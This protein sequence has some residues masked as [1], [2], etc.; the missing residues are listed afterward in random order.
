MLILD[1][2]VRSSELK[3]ANLSEG[4]LRTEIEKF[5][6]ARGGPEDILVAALNTQGKFFYQLKD[7]ARHRA[8]IQGG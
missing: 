5:G 1:G 8:N 6:G 7:Q 3:K 4:W 2:R